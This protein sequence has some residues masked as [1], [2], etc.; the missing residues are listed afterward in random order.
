MKKGFH[1]AASCV[2]QRG[3]ICYAA[4]LMT[5]C[6]VRAD[7]IMTL[8]TTDRGL[9]G[10]D[11]YHIP[12]YTPY[13]VGRAHGSTVNNFLVYDMSSI[14]Q[15]VVSAELRLVNNNSYDSPDPY[16]TYTVFDVTTPLW[17]LQNGYGD[18]VATYNDLG[19]GIVY[20]STDVVSNNGYVVVSVYLNEAGL[21]ALNASLGGMFVVGGAITSLDSPE[22]T[23]EHLFSLSDPDRPGDGA[24]QLV[25]T[26]VPE[27]GTLGLLALGGLALYATRR[28]IRSSSFPC[29]P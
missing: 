20:G 16:E 2:R 29:V 27:P 8:N 25:L 11:G 3:I 5:V 19:S 13:G 4:V 15:E 6:C 10:E 1:P 24:T 17:E 23:Y 9:Y 14:T 18:T 7:M 22:A 21:A 26:F 28:R 12:W